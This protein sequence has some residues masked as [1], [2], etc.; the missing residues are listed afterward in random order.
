MRKPRPIRIAARPTFAVVVDGETEVWYLQMLKRNEREI[1]VNV[2]PKIPQRKKLKDQYD[3]VLSLSADYTKVFW[4]VDLDVIISE[5]RQTKA[6]VL[7]PIQELINYKREINRKYDNVVLIVN[8]PCLEF[9]LLLHFE[10]TNKLFNTC[11]EA[12]TQLKMHLKN[13]EKSQK[14]FTKQDNDI[15]LQLKSNVQ[16]A[17]S[18]AKATGEFDENDPFKAVSE[19]HLFFESSEF[20]KLFG[21]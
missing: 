8:N 6:G 14:Y 18:H 9:W 11:E 15:Y 17:L 21:K 5:T 12:Q 10:K 13:Y 7:N 1:S 16:N 19:M 20:N 4:I 3:S 2:E